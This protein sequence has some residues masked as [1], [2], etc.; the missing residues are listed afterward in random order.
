MKTV[1]ITYFSDVLC[2][3]AY[4]AQLRVNAIHEKFDG[5]VTFDRKFCSVF[6][7]T[8]RKMATT[9]KDKGGYEG[10]NAHLRHVDEQFPEIA[11]NPDIWLTARPASSMGPHLY[12]KAVQLAEAGGGC[13]AGAADRATWAFRQAFF[14]QARDIGAWAVQCEV[15]SSVGIDA[16][17]VEA[18]IHDGSAHAALSSDYKDADAAGIQGSPSFVLNDGR[19]TLFGN[20][21][22]RVIDANI[23]E[24]LRAPTADQA[25]WC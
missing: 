23:Q 17:A 18:L 19:Q 25:S 20:V 2:I 11:I 24:L 13:D 9:W 14:E 5:Q 3:W 10:F 22:F 21:G 4:I 12:L 7:D 16:K 15:A 1:P 8:A 6:G